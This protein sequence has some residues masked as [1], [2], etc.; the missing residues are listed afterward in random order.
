LFEKNVDLHVLE[1]VRQNLHK[2]THQ[3]VIKLWKEN[4]KG[5]NLINANF[6]M[7][8][9]LKDEEKNHHDERSVANFD[10]KVQA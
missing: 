8:K 9:I 4:L 7:Q 5:L 6:L 2:K 1:F 3:N 10:T